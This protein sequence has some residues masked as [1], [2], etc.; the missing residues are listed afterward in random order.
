M[1]TTEKAQELT[2]TLPKDMNSTSA[3]IFGPSEESNKTDI[4]S[5]LLWKRFFLQTRNWSGT[6]SNKAKQTSFQFII[7]DITPDPLSFVKALFTSK[8]AEFQM[9]GLCVYFCI[10]LS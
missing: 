8:D 9:E 3:A 1:H 6:F 7:T 5:A 10:N 4:E 2:T